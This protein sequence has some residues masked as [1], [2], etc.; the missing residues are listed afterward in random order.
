MTVYYN[1]T[2]KQGDTAMSNTTQ[3]TLYVSSPQLT[4]H[5]F[6]IE[7]NKSIVAQLTANGKVAQKTLVAW[8][9]RQGYT[10]IS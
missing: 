9:T 2:R 6:K 3:A 7:G 1:H 4:K 5:V 8:I 10:V